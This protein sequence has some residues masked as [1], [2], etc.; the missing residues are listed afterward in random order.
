MRAL[1][2]DVF[3]DH[4][5]D[6]SNGGITSRFNELLIICPEGNIEID[7]SATLPENLC[8]VVT[9]DLG[10]GIYKHIEPVAKANGVGWMSG[11]CIGYTCDSRFRRMSEYPL[12]IH[13]RTENQKE[14]NMYSV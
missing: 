3:R 5:G 1:R 7:E 4:Y 14:Y 2:V 13:D 12:L 6:C 11:G 10:F 9:R 8:K